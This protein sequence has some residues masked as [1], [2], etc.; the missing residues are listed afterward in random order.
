[1]KADKSIYFISR[2]RE[3]INEFLIRELE[4]RGI[5]GIVPSHADVLVE[6][7]RN[8][9]LTMTEIANKIHKDRSTVTTLVN[10]L[11]K[12]EYVKKRKNEN[13]SRSSYVCI[14]EKGRALEPD[15]KEISKD[16]FGMIYIG[17]SEEEREIFLKV[18]KKIFDNVQ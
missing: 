15:F 4:K 18:L 8:G 11:I 5:D 7:R 14:T 17:V 3:K 1:M 16:M 6:L 9:D 2:I 10:K 12:L 13:D